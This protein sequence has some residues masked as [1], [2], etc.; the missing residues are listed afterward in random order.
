MSSQSSNIIYELNI[1]SIK[2]SPKLEYK[3][4]NINY[5]TIS[6]TN[7]KLQTPIIEIINNIKRLNPKLQIIPYYSLKYHQKNTLLDTIEEFLKYLQSLY[8]L[9]IKEVLLVSGAPKP[10]YDSLLILQNINKFDKLIKIAVAYNPF[11]KS[12]D[13][14]LENIRIKDKIKTGLISSIY[15]QIGI[16]TDIIQNSIIYLRKLQPNINIYLSLINPT[17][18]RLTQLKYRPWK[19]V[20]LP[21][22]YLSS[23]ENAKTI[24]LAIYNLASKMKVGI[25]QGD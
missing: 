17:S 22:Q 5:P 4:K 16:D 15:L 7:K 3:L 24:N 25:I 23:P 2:F 18:S 20:Y 12:S 19:G 11:L 10:K 1:N 14:E 21:E 13:L 8:S 9:D 6:I